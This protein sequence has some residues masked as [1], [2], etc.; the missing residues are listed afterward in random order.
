MLRLAMRLTKRDEN[1]AKTWAQKAIAGGV[2]ENA[3]DNAVVKYFNTGQVYN[4]NPV[5][6]EI[7]AQDYKADA[8]GDA[9]VEGGKFSKAF[10][11]F[12]KNNNDP[13]LSVMAVTYNGTTP[14]TTSSIAKGLPSGTLNKPNNFKTFSE[15]N[16]ATILRYDAPLLVLTNA[17]MSFLL[18]EAACAAGPTPILL[19]AYFKNG[20]ENN[21]RNWSRF[22]AAGVI[23]RAPHCGVCEQ[24]CAEYRWQL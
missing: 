10:I 11:D 5:A 18:S 19:S 17:E 1:K 21:M 14:D 16:P 2:I 23:A 4:F 8:Y 20:I 12:L 22:G 9:N 3:A 15:L 13:R 6:Y 24:S 7:G